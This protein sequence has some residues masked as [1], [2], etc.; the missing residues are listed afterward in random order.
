M[1][2]RTVVKIISFSMAALIASFGFSFLIYSRAKN[3]FLEIERGYSRS[4]DDLSAGINNISLTLKKAQYINTPAQLS[5]MAAKLLSEAEISKNSL[6][7]L[8][9]GDDLTLVNRFLSQVGNCAAAVSK[10]LILNGESTA[11]DKE[12]LEN[13]SDTAGKIAKIVNEA[14]ITYNNAEYWAREL[15]KKIDNAIDGENLGSAL[16]EIENEL[17]DYPTLVYDGPYSDHIFEKEPEMLKDAETVSKN[18]AL[19]IAART[20]EWDKSLLETDGEINGKMPAYRFSGQGVTA[21]VTM[22]GGYPLYMRKERVI[23]DSLLSYEQA[24]EKAKRYLSRMEMSGFTETYYSINEGVCVINMAYLD[25]ETVCYTDLLKVGVAMDNGEIMLF[26]GS[27]YISNHKSRAFETPLH[28]AEEAQ[29]KLSENLTVNER[30]IALIPTDSAGEVRCYEF[31]CTAKNGEEIL[32]Y[33]N[34]QTLAE[35]D[36]LILLKSDGGVLVK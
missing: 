13:L 2:K 11:T 7:Q 30:S 6:S 32:I 27:G 20:V 21:T 18:E 36:I 4:L 29:G 22:R 14:Q 10:S 17:T 8:P 31:K 9:A 23:T 33:I 15:D 16:G 3:Y 1:K 19:E 12:N 26:E 35:E 34:T 28:K 25:G 24:L 5:T